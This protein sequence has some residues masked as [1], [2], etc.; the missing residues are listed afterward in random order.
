[1]ALVTGGGSGIGRCIA[2]ELA[3]LGAH[4]VLASR[5]VDKLRAV[6]QEIVA[7]GGAASVAQCNIRSEDEVDATVASVVSSLGRLDCLVNNAGGQFLA[8]PEDISPKG[9]RAVI[10]TNLSGTFFASRSAHRQWMRAHGGAIVNIVADFWNGMP[11]MAHTAAARA[12]VANLTKSLALAWAQHGVRINS[13]APGTIRSSGLKNYPPAI[14][15]ALEGMIRETPAKRLGTESE[16]SAAVVFL[17]SPAAAFITGDTLRVDG[18]S[19]IYRQMMPIANH[20]RLPPF[21]AFH[22]DADVPEEL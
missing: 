11:M 19:S 16:V 14:V 4:V 21:S 22:L 9:W 15:S 2:H 8:R 7:A 17:L 18:G 3:S 10:E 5:N 12:G 13:V 6:E 1:V 20:D